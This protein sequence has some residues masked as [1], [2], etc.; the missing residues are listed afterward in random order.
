MYMAWCIIGPGDAVGCNSGPTAV[1]W[2]VSWT[3]CR[4]PGIH[5]NMGYDRVVHNQGCKLRADREVAS[6]CVG[7]GYRNER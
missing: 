1:R 6:S 2:L 7:G 4:M 5:Y 3:Q